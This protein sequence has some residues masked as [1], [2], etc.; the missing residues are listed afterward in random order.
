MP[1]IFRLYTGGTQ[2]FTDWYGTP[3]FPYIS[4]NRDTIEDPDGATARHEITSIPSPFAR[5]DLVKNAFREVVKS[6]DLDGK[7]IFHKMVSDAFDVGEIFFNIDK[8]GD[9]VEIITWNVRSSIERLRD[10]RNDGQRYLGDAL[11]KYLNTDNTNNFGDL[12]NIY[13]LNFKDGPDRLNIIGA[14]SPATLFFSNANDLSYVS[15]QLVFNLDKPFDGE[16]QPLY[17]RDFSYVEALFMFRKNF[18][19]FARKFPEV[20]DYFDLTLRSMQNFNKDSHAKLRDIDGAATNYDT[21][22]A[23]HQGQVNKVEVLGYDIPRKVLNVEEIQS[24]FEIKPTRESNEHLL[25][26]PVEAGNK[27]SRLMYVTGEW[28]RENVAPFFDRTPIDQRSLPH[29]GTKMGYLTISDFLEDY[30]VKIPHKLNRASFF[31]GNIDVRG[32]RS[33]FLLPLKPLFFKYFSVN[34]LISNAS[35]MLDMRPLAG[36]GVAVTL[37][38]PIKGNNQIKHVEYERL[39][40]ANNSPDAGQNKGEVVVFDFTGIVMPFVRFNDEAKAIYTVA[41]VFNPASAFPYALS[42]YKNEMLISSNVECRSRYYD[43]AFEHVQQKADVYTISHSN[44]DYIQVAQAEWRG[45]LIPKFKEQRQNNQL[46]FAVDLGTSN[47]HIEV[48]RQENAETQALSYTQN[49]CLYKE[50]FEQSRDARQN[51]VD[52]QEEQELIDKDFLPEI[53]GNGSDFKF[54]TRTALSVAKHS[55]VNEVI[56]FA[57]VNVPLTQDKRVSIRYND[58]KFNIKWG[59]T[60]EDQRNLES[61]VDCLMLMLRNVALTEDGDLN[62]TQLVW[63]YPKS[64]SQYRLGFLKDVWNKTF[65]KY[66]NGGQTKCMTESFAPIQYYFKRYSTTTN[67]LNIDIGGGTTDAAYATDRQI[68]FTTSFR[69]ATNVLFE[70]SYSPLDSNNGIVDYHK[71]AIRN[72]ISART[73]E[74]DGL[75]KAYKKEP[76]NMASFLFSLKQNS[77]LQKLNSNSID[78]NFILGNDDKFKVIFLIYYTAII[79]HLTQVIKLKGLPIPRH[80]SFGG[81]GSKIINVITTDTDLLARFTKL[82]FEKVF[83]EETNQPLEILGL[84]ENSSSKE[85]TCKGGLQATEEEKESDNVVLKSNGKAFVSEQDVYG[86][87]DD[88][89]KNEVVNSVK[90]FF[91]F[92]FSL[93]KTLNFTEN[94]GVDASILKAVKKV[95]MNDA[96]TF[97]NRGLHNAQAEG[98]AQGKIEETFFFFPI[99]GIINAL[100]TF[101]FNSL[102][103]RNEK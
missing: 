1:H 64:M 103:D 55:D 54:P 19:N 56:P 41:S 31:D 52:L 28:G 72:K 32:E 100:S 101:I 30:I 46:T 27:Y 99:K 62:R 50:F 80:I 82:I 87:I 2:S 73:Q 4:N 58:V 77:K 51:V 8:F 7:T 79:Y 66:F 23:R 13:L 43:E 60:P 69:F 39:Y 76:A 22:N 14:T 89:Y 3:A 84:N 29:D 47:T 85:S 90:E 96:I 45:L 57:E 63:F 5:I 35:R 48:K 67:L 36:G 94:F 95:C 91:D 37:R 26:L 74:L 78:F 18:P 68:R 25:V 102:K 10:S 34:D 16:Y 75:F 21:I 88:A 42:F 17:K 98:D 83:G 33:S 40:F 20:N 15:N 71:D 6:R 70:N 53:V 59:N 9:K 93:N 24:D 65:Q 86:N 92:F 38:I 44:F 49:Q 12:E 11:N 81:N 61:Y 97:L